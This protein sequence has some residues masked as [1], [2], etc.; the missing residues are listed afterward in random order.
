MIRK[1]H[2]NQEKVFREIMKMGRIS[3]FAVRQFEPC[4]DRKNHKTCDTYFQAY[5]N[6]R[7][8]LT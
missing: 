6:I 3:Q 4:C 8:S 5:V 1:F 7:F 2:E